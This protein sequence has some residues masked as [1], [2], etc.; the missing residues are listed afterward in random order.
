M[1]SEMGRVEDLHTLVRLLKEFDLP[2]SPILEYAIKEKMD[3]FGENF[4]I[5]ESIKSAEPSPEKS[6]YLEK[7]LKVEFPDGTVICETYASETLKK[8]INKIGPHMVE[9]LCFSEEELRPYDVD[10]VS[11]ER[12]TDKRYVSSQHPLDYGYYLFTKT[13]TNAKKRQLEVISRALS[14]SLKVDV[15]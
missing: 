15:V 7:G 4:V 10:L 13:S 8:A 3:S 11:K 9:I 1:Y 12:I 6:H 14:L 2:V 5:H